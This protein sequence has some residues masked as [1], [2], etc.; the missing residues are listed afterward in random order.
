MADEEVAADI[1]KSL[2]LITVENAQR[3]DQ[4]AGAVSGGADDEVFLTA[5]ALVGNAM[6]EALGPAEMGAK[7]DVERFWRW[8]G[9]CRGAQAGSCK[10]KVISRALRRTA[11][12]PSVAPNHASAHNSAVWNAA[13]AAVCSNVRKRKHAM[14]RTLS[15]FAP[16]R[17]LSCDANSTDTLCALPRTVGT[18][19]SAGTSLDA[20]AKL[21]RAVFQKL[22]A[23]AHVIRP[24]RAN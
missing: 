21:N 23:Q 4:R 18:E 15:K 14:Q 8:G 2:D 3:K 16:R 24:Y 5:M 7:E 6:K 22:T 12:Y 9:S 10:G 17:L 20:L 19:L 13:R 1:S 11:S